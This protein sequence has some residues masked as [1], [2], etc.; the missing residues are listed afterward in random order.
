MEGKEVFS[1]EGKFVT[2][3]MDTGVVYCQV[4]KKED[5]V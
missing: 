1:Q 3:S 2:I 5:V 4:V